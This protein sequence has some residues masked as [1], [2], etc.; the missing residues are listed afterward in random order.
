VPVKL[1]GRI[2]VVTGAASGIGRA[3][4]LL[5]AERGCHLALVDVQEAPLLE[6]ADQARGLGVEV[7]THVVDVSDKAAMAALPDSVAAAHGGVHILENNA[8][9]TAAGPF[10]DL[11]IETFEWVLGIN[12][13]GVIYGCKF[14]APLLMA[15]DEAHIV[16]ISSVFGIA[17]VPGQSAYCASKFAVRG[18]SETLWEELAHTHIGVT[19]VHPAGVR[20]AISA[21]GRVV[22]ERIR[23]LSEEPFQASGVTPEHAA[24]KIADAIERDRARVRIGWAAV[25]F[26]WARRVAPVRG[27]RVLGKLVVKTLR[28]DGYFK[29]QRDAYETARASRVSG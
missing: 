25:A 7:S 6:V 21:S 17:G 24:R 8:G 1:A 26:D 5:L 27:N 4:G 16:N 19:V 29:E 15:A 9:V 10:D 22:D 23:E 18:F 13:W 28:L 2:A 14:F 3:L 20:T 12:L 11:D